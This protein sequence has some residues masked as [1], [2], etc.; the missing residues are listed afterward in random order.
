MAEAA[1]DRPQRFFCHQCSVE[2]NP[3][4]PDYTCPRC[5]SGFIEEMSGGSLLE[6]QHTDNNETP[7]MMMDPAA[8]FE[9]LWERT[10]ADSFQLQTNEEG[11]HSPTDGVHL[12]TQ[13][14]PDS[15]RL[16]EE[17]ES[18]PPRLPGQRRHPLLSQVS[19]GQRQPRIT[20]RRFTSSRPDR[21]PAIEGIISQLLSSL[22]GGALF[23]AEGMP[24][25]MFQLHGNPGDYAWGADGLD[26]I[27]S[28]LLNQLEGS[29]APPANKQQIDSLPHR[30][31][32][33]EQVENRL[34]CTVCMEDFHLQEE[35][36][37]LPCQHYYHTDCIVPWLERHGTCPICRKDM[38]GRDTSE[39]ETPL[40]IPNLDNR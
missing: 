22:A 38:N 30:K 3:D 36:R 27:V 26:A 6:D 16:T 20:A 32:T 14:E 1:V 34:Q 2:I 19:V 7:M 37:L 24:I 18:R 40:Q 39:D 10:F 31:V 4:L 9:E 13:V 11:L 28:Q 8:Q 21:H 5:D 15:N 23:Q 25:G 35:V 29:G 33:K 17:E 12:P